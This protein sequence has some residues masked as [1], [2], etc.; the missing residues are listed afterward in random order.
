MDRSS[1]ILL[2]L[3][4]LTATASASGLLGDDRESKP[5]HALS[6]S[7]P[8]PRSHIVNFNVNWANGHANTGAKAAY[9]P[10]VR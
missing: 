2:L 3:T 10:S 6:G 9:D 5:W 7:Q 4:A 8:A 1:L